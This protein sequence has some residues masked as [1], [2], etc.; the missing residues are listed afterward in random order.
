M[1]ETSDVCDKFSKSVSY[2]T[3]V[4]GT[5]TIGRDRK[6]TQRL[7][8][9]TAGKPLSA[10][11]TLTSLLCNSAKVVEKLLQMSPV[12][13]L[14]KILGLVL[15]LSFG[16]IS[17]SSADD[18]INCLTWQQSCGIN[19]CWSYDSETKKLSIT[20]GADGSVG[21]MDDYSYSGAHSNY[22]TNTPWDDYRGQIQ[23]VDIKD[24]GNVGKNAFR[25]FNKIKKVNMDENITSIGLEAFVNCKITNLQLP[26]SIKTIGRDAFS[27]NEN[28]E[29]FIP[30]TLEYMGMQK[31]S[32]KRYIICKGNEDT[33]LKIQE[34]LNIVGE[35]EFSLAKKEQCTG[36]NYYWS[37]TNCNNKKNGI[38]C[39][40]AYSFDD[41]NNC[42]ICD[43]QGYRNV[44]GYCNRIRYT[45]AEAAKVL[46]NDNTNEITIAFKK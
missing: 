45:P 27:L 29:M 7:S 30:D 36:T 20:G 26:D 14:I 18:A 28:S 3:L 40:S 9:G 44:D 11:G 5:A 43:K 22:K 12:F 1:L 41:E 4:G 35:Y 10:V 17:K 37:G 39:A 15:V 23:S 42:I 46:H 31:N 33:C 6:Q 24:V 25:Y 32:T 19:C 21:V 8:E 13:R 2:E 38:R 34:N 16:I